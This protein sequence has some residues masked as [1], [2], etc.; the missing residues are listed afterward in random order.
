MTSRF[1]KHLIYCLIMA[2]TFASLSLRAQEKSVQLANTQQFTLHSDAVNDNFEIMVGLPFGYSQSDTRYKVLYVLD[3]NVTFGMVNDIQTLISFEPENPPMIVIGIGYKDFGNW[4]QK[5]ARDYMP[6]QVNTA[7]G[8]GGAGKFLQFL[9]EQLIPHINQEYRTTESR[10]LYGHSTAG[11]FG[12]YTI[13]QKP[14]L[15]EGYIITS[16]SVDEDKGYSQQQVGH[17]PAEVPQPVRVFLSSG[18]REKTS[19]QTAYKQFLKSFKRWEEQGI[20]VKSEE[21]DASHMSSMA[22]AFVKGLEYVNRT[23]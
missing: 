9:E 16:P 1:F 21:F 19:F 22:P 4:I 12:L 7:P 14:N 8:S 3:A 23:H 20:K 13:F 18:S 17:T 5:R 11:L 15:F 10:L 6:T 2:L